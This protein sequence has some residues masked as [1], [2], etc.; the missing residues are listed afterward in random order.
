[1]KT[2]KVYKKLNESISTDKIKKTNHNNFI[3]NDCN[4]TN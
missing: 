3:N 2:F 4:E 1:M